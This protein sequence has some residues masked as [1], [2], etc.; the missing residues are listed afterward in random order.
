MVVRSRPS[1]KKAAFKGVG[2]N[3][4]GKYVESEQIALHDPALY[5]F[6]A[7][8]KPLEGFESVDSE[9]IQ[10]FHDHGFIAVENAFSP[11]EVRDGLDGLEHLALGQHSEFKNIM[12]ESA[13]KD[14]LAG[15]SEAERLDA[16]RKMMYFVDCEPR[17]N[18]IA[19]HVDL[20]S[21]LRQ[22]VGSEELTMFQDM[23]LMKPPSIGREKPWHQDCA[24]FDV[25]PQSPIV[26]VWIALDEAGLDNGCMRVLD[27]GHQEGPQIHFERRDWQIC[28]ADV[29]TLHTTDHPVVA[30]P[31]KPGGCMFFS[32]LLPHGTPHN[33]SAKRRRALQFHYRPSNTKTISTDERLAVF[34]SEGKDVYC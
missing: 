29:E 11:Q 22:L 4:D 1:S 25:P 6:D 31:L 21:V 23:A 19:C 10:Y 27:G 5:A 28:D 34:G 16:I 7:V 15:L 17:L 9:A 8:A 12:F 3:V 24:Y 13:A 14:Q 32:G 26:G 2:Q 18:A 20:L 30:V 33:T